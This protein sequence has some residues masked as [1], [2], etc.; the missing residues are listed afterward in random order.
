M[1]EKYPHHHEFSIDNTIRD[2]EQAT[3]ILMLCHKQPHQSTT[4]YPTELN[5]CTTHNFISHHAHYTF[6]SLSLSFF[7]T[8]PPPPHPFNPPSK[9]PSNS[10][11][12]T[13]SRPNI[14]DLKST[15]PPMSKPKSDSP[16]PP[17]TMP[18]P[19]PITHSTVT[20]L[21]RELS[22]N[23]IREDVLLTLEPRHLLFCPFR[24]RLLFKIREIPLR[25]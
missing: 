13:A 16:I 23:T 2:D 18:S 9:N 22:S 17:L 21:S 6:F 10:P 12:S 3:P 14:R 24:R 1:K 8:A 19:P 11:D 20:T 25:V 15:S 7:S 5:F 4:S